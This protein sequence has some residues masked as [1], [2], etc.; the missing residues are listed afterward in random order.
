MISYEET[1]KSI[2][3]FLDE[4]IYDGKVLAISGEWGVGK[5]HL[6]NSSQLNYRKTSYNLKRN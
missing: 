1:Q 5:T 3:K 2:E 6:I 4:D